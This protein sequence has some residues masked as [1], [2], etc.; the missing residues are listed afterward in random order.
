MARTIEDV[1]YLKEN[2]EIVTKVVLIDSNLRNKTE[3]PDSSEYVIHLNEPMY[4]VV[5]MRM[6]EATVPNSIITTDVGFKSMT[7]KTGFMANHARGR[8]TGTVTT[9]AYDAENLLSKTS[10]IKQIF[11]SND[12]DV[13]IFTI[14]LSTADINYTLFTST[15]PFVF[16]SGDKG[17]QRLLG[18]KE[19]PIL[20]DDLD[21]GVNQYELEEGILTDPVTKKFRDKS[22]IRGI[23]KYTEDILTGEKLFGS[24]H[25]TTI[26]SGNGYNYGYDAVNQTVVTRNENESDSLNNYEDIDVDTGVVKS[27]RFLVTNEI[28]SN[29]KSAMLTTPDNIADFDQ[30]VPASQSIAADS[31]IKKSYYTKVN[32]TTSESAPTIN[33]G[34]SLEINTTNTSYDATTDATN[35]SESDI[36]NLKDIANLRILKQGETHY[37]Y[38]FLDALTQTSTPNNTTFN[39]NCP[40]SLRFV[41]GTEQCYKQEI[42][43]NDKDAYLTAYSADTPRIDEDAIAPD[44]NLSDLIEP[45]YG[46]RLTSYT[47]DPD[48]VTTHTDLDIG[49]PNYMEN[50]SIM[51]RNIY[52]PFQPLFLD[53]IT[54][55]FIKYTGS[56]GIDTTVTP[57]QNHSRFFK[58]FQELFQY[59]SLQIQTPE[60]AGQPNFNPDLI[61]TTRFRYNN[62]TY[63][64]FQTLLDDI[65]R[66]QLILDNFQSLQTPM[67]NV[68]VNGGGDILSNLSWEIYDM[69]EANITETEHSNPTEFTSNRLLVHGTFD[70]TGNDVANPATSFDKPIKCL[71]M[72]KIIRNGS[73]RLDSDQ[74][75]LI[76]R[77]NNDAASSIY[78]QITRIGIKIVNNSNFP[79][80]LSCMPPYF[81]TSKGNETRV[82]KLKF[83]VEYA[84][85]KP[86]NLGIFASNPLEP[87]RPRFTYDDYLVR[88]T[89][90]LTFQTSKYIKLKCKEFDSLLNNTEF[91]NE[92]MSPSLGIFAIIDFRFLT[93]S[94][95]T[96]SHVSFSYNELHPIGK[97]SK[98][99]FR[100][101]NE[102]G[103]L[104]SF[105]G[106]DHYFLLGI[107][108]RRF[109]K[110][111]NFGY[112]Q[113]NPNY[114]YDFLKY[115]RYNAERE[116]RTKVEL[117][118]RN[119][120]GLMEEF[121][122]LQ[123][124]NRIKHRTDWETNLMEKRMAK[125]LA[126][127]I[128][129]RLR[130]GDNVNKVLGKQINNIVNNILS[131]NVSLETLK[132]V[133]GT[134]KPHP[135][136][137]ASVKGLK[138][139]MAFN[140][141]ARTVIN[142]EIAT[143]TQLGAI[144]DTN[145][146][147]VE[148][149]LVKVEGQLRD[150]ESDITNLTKKQTELR[151][152]AGGATT[153]PVLPIAGEI[154]IADRLK[155]GLADTIDSQ[156][157]RLYTSRQRKQN[158]LLDVDKKA[159]VYAQVK[160]DLTVPFLQE[161]EVKDKIYKTFR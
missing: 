156:L 157:Q 33:Y 136:D 46:E 146:A 155:L 151:T 125:N 2:S 69:T 61:E 160:Q 76:G 34:L 129:D 96:L 149:D 133:V 14:D 124:D 89:S 101:V 62:T 153:Q 3:F 72:K 86:H 161:H 139:I 119:I 90:V 47:N 19:T 24:Y 115:L 5:N 29:Y 27:F 11:T 135:D 12:L 123:E 8:V 51:L 103:L 35:N 4:N 143:K 144:I 16:A 109:N 55:T 50:V 25:T 63:E 49:E 159:T 120:E 91:A 110:K 114:D 116:E 106:L 128:S 105:K 94:T 117:P 28:V 26:D 13:N 137:A 67:S 53:L 150:I 39:Q 80:P 95:P 78:N 30:S 97:L 9:K 68:L 131:E 32:A 64:T 140:Q 36:K 60:D 66:E 81:Y 40:N 75:E 65:P 77:I 20:G 88:S 17:L 6:L 142:Q 132:R 118:E 154:S 82:R 31:Y 122:E 52:V 158:T 38:I 85:Y 141:F 93:Y 148:R 108:Y 127:R 18:Y 102:Q 23:Y 58:D 43:Y 138:T 42:W 104:M 48:F 99:T 121:K 107:E 59:T 71:R 152:Q 21:I 79:L 45:F 74:A 112:S 70:Y 56:V 7:L 54:E 10:L 147:K 145:R 87:H 73:D 1:Q 98:L 126:L 37:D 83:G 22:K 41:R 15:T 113:L 92:A 111:M 44:I 84:G 134:I 130:E 100:F 57:N